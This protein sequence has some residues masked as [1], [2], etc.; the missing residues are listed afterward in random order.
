[1]ITCEALEITHR[2]RDYQV[3]RSVPSGGLEMA[4]SLSNRDSLSDMHTYRCVTSP[5]PL[6][7]LTVHSA[8]AC[9]LRSI[10]FV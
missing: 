4:V 5:G 2:E 10:F 1:M 7:A 8:V 3:Q 6:Y 9:R